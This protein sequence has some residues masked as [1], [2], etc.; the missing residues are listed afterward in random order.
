MILIVPDAV[1]YAIKDADLVQFRKKIRHIQVKE[2]ERVRLAAIDALRNTQ[3]DR[4]SA[5]AAIVYEW[6]QAY[7]D[8]D[9]ALRIR[10]L[11]GEK[12]PHVIYGARYL[13]GEP[14]ND[15]H[16]WATLSVGWPEPT[17]D[18]LPTLWY[19]ENYNTSMGSDVRE[20]IKIVT[21]QALVDGL[22]PDYLIGLKQHLEGPDCWKHILQE[23]ARRFP[24]DP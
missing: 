6:C 11:L 23:L 24:V 14:T 1:R 17:P 22:H 3:L 10:E 18:S 15:R 16:A 12:T 19:K 2:K 13:F 20:T 4:L 7:T 9:E 21:V 5:Y 8:T